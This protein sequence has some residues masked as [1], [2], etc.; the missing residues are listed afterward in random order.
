MTRVK[1][2]RIGREAVRPAGP[3]SHDGR[4]G[5]RWEALIGGVELGAARGGDV[6]RI[7]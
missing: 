4:G 5:V 3:G 6:T 1:F 2:L 7:G